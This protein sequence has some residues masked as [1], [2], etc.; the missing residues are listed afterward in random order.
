MYECLF[1]G[2]AAGALDDEQLSSGVTLHFMP[3]RS[4]AHLRL[5]EAIARDASAEIEVKGLN[6]FARRTVT[7]LTARSITLAPA[8]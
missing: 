8:P 7:G 5:V 3:Y 1:D 6:G 2:G 4:P